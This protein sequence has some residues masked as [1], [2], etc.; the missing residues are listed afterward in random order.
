MSGKLLIRNWR[1]CQ[2]LV[3]E[4]IL[5]GGDFHAVE[6]GYMHQFEVLEDGVGF[7]LYWAEF[8][9]ND[10]VREYSGFNRNNPPEDRGKDV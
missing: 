3:D 2:D 5:E 8:N 6:P 7:E 1:H 10:I 4:T 9:H